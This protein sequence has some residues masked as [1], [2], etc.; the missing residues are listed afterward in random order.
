[1]DLLCSAVLAAD[2]A[3]PENGYT[4]SIRY[5]NT[6]NGYDPIIICDQCGSRI[7]KATEGVAASPRMSGQ[8]GE[9]EPC[10]HL[11]LGACHDAWEARQKQTAGWDHLEVH[12]A[13]LVTNLGLDVPAEL[14]RGWGVPEATSF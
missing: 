7:A 12:L 11:H 9:T 3:D 4:M 14:L 8:V 2:L 13:R 5:L 6:A 1:M 10:A